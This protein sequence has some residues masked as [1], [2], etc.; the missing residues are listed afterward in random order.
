[1]NRKPARFPRLPSAMVTRRIWTA[2]ALGVVLSA[3]VGCSMMG[4]TLGSTLPRDLRRVYVPTFENV[5]G[6]P[7]LEAETTAAAVREFQKD[8]TLQVVRT[9]AEADLVLRVKVVKFALEPLRYDQN[10]E[11]KATEYRMRIDARLECEN[12]RAGTILV[13]QSVQGHTDFTP[14]GGLTVSKQDALPDAAADLAHKI[15]K[16]VVE[17][18]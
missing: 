18:W 15:V 2:A 1:M 12:R 7:Q 6:E 14:S 8:G 10:Q 5:S 16:S 4:Y 11:K 9:E 13:A 17:A 3:G